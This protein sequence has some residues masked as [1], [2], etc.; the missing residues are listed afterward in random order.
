MKKETANPTPLPPPKSWLKP[1]DFPNLVWRRGG[2]N[3]SSTSYKYRR[4]PGGILNINYS[5]LRD[6]IPAPGSPVPRTLVKANLLRQTSEGQ[7]D[8]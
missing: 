6:E 5:R 7:R 1:H 8:L 3:F 4:Q 2:I